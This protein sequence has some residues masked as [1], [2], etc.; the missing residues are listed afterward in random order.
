MNIPSTLSLYLQGFTPPLG[1]ESCLDCLDVCIWVQPG[2]HREGVWHW[3]QHLLH[4]L[5]TL[6]GKRYLLFL[7]EALEDT[8]WPYDTCAHYGTYQPGALVRDKVLQVPS[9]I[10]LIRLGPRVWLP[11]IIVSWGVVATLFAG[12]KSATD[13]YVL[14]LLLGVAESGSFPGA[15]CAVAFLTPALPK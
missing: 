1:S 8:S 2:L 13:F 6:P 12:L 5:C 3:V 10:V 15:C 14:R 11:I 9:N 4:R 7:L